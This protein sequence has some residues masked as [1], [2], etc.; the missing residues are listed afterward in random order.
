LDTKKINDLVRIFS[1][2][3]KK[4]NK[5]FGIVGPT[6]CFSHPFVCLHSTKMVQFKKCYSFQN[7]E[8][9]SISCIR[10]GIYTL[11]NIA[12]FCFINLRIFIKQ[13]FQ[14]TVAAISIVANMD[15][16]I[17]KIFKK[18]KYRM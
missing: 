1:L 16:N 17:I 13:I 18:P 15:A 11:P 9:T 6:S 5:K 12:T 8:V 10:K 3:A 2:S 4:K 14:I 7:K